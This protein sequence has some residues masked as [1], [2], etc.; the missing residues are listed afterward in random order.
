MKLDFMQRLL[1]DNRCTV[2]TVVASS[3]PELVI[4]K[5]DT[6]LCIVPSWLDAAD[7][8]FVEKTDL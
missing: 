6:A 3:I 7:R 2:C 1:T 8:C 5:R 4:F